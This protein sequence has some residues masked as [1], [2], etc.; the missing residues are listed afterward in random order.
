MQ[1]DMAYFLG[2]LIGGGTITQDAISIEFPYK[3]WDREDYRIPPKWFNDSVTKIVPLIKNLLNANAAPRC[4][5]DH[6]PR[7]YIDINPIP[8]LLYEMLREYGI[9]PLGQLRRQASISKLVLKMDESCQR[10]F[11]SGLADVI[12]SCRPTHRHRTLESAI[13]S[14]EIIGKNWKLPFELCQLLYGLK[15]PVNQIE[16]NHPNMHAGSDSKGYWK[17]GHKVRVRAGDF[18][19]IGYGMDCKRGGLEKLLRIE[20]QKR[21]SIRRGELCPNRR[22]NINRV[23]VV[24]QDENSSDLPKQVRGHFIHF[25]HICYALGCPHAPVSWL[26]EKMPK[27]MPRGMQSRAL[28]N[29]A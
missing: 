16:W 4:V 11:V 22:Y 26:K 12:G 18:E 25:T 15:V 20:K 9:R 27:Y 1:K 3:G 8:N 19:K 24:H 13:V 2:L 7:Y 23:K 17:K 28:T 10:K 5:T 29:F 21:G 14:F 6:T